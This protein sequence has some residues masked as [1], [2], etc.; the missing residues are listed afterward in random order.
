MTIEEQLK[1]L[2]LS[3]Y[4]SVRA[5]STVTKIPY[6]TLDNIFRRGIGG[7]GVSTVYKI[8]DTLG[9]TVEG[10]THGRLERRESRST[11]DVSPQEIEMLEHYRKLDARGKA[12][13]DST[14]SR[15]YA[16]CVSIA[17]A[18]DAAQTVESA[19]SMISQ[20]PAGVK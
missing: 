14:L 2:I 6:S 4:K 8:C 3:Q 17:A 12:A 19:N 18:A 11:L 7:T 5:F 1:E 20:A 16:A 9:I 15:E 10:I 13:V